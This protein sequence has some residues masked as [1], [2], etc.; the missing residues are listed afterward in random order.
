MPSLK[1]DFQSAYDHHLR[2]IGL[3]LTPDMDENARWWLDREL[4]ELV[5]DMRASG[6]L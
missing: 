1:P 2:L 3:F 5:K 6:I 4:D